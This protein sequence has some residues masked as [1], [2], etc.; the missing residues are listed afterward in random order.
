MPRRLKR[1]KVTVTFKDF[2]GARRQE[3]DK[4][5]ARNKADAERKGLAFAKK[6]KALQST[7]HK[8]VRVIDVDA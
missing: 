4:I 6:Y 2:R 5:L 3:T 8:V 7:N 1:Y